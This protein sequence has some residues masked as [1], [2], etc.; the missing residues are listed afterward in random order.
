MGRATAPSRGSFDSPF[1][2]DRPTLGAALEK[3][4]SAPACRRFPCLRQHAAI[5][6][7]AVL[8]SGSNRAMLSKVRGAPPLLL[9][10]SVC[11][12]DERGP[13]QS[14]ALYMT[15]PTAPHTPPTLTLRLAM[16]RYLLRCCSFVF[17]VQSDL[18]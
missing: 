11:V 3:G 9:D 13:S 7:A 15:L 14:Y 5:D 10:V 12:W 18:L 8:R 2:C 1:D 16:S 17:P 4:C 6:A